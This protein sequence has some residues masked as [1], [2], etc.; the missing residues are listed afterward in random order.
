MGV[1]TPI[2]STLDSFW[3]SAKAG[4]SGVCQITRFDVSAYDVKIAAEVKDFNPDA[5]I[6][7]KEQRRMDMY[8]QYAVA[9]AKMAMQDSGLDMA[10]ENPDRAGVIAGSGIGGLQTLEIQHT[11]LREKGPGRC[12]PFM[13]PQMIS[14]IAA[15]MIAI[16]F[17]MKG[18]NYSVISACATAAHCAGDALRLIQRGDADIMIAGGAEATICGLGI[19]G[20]ASMKALST[21]NDDPAHASR[22]FDRERDGFVMGEGA[23]ML[24]IEELE[25]A[26]KRNARIYC[27]LAGFGMTCDA[28]HI[29]APIEDGSGAGRAMSL[30]MSEA[31]VTPDQVTYI[32]A[33]GTSTPL[34]DKVETLAIKRALGDE[35]ARRVMVSS[36]KSMTGHMLGAAGGIE[37]VVCAMAIRDGIVPPTANYEFPDPD[38]DLDYVPNTARQA[39][40]KVCLNNSLGFGGHSACLLFRKLA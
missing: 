2:G 21:R 33:H 17:N 18:P 35:N 34:N 12:S 38:C 3:A 4:K 14:N 25:H 32:N 31:G 26:K 30:A 19:A 7:K 24:V 27:E 15:G 8:C 13:I 6:A 10:A 5:F 36:T 11:I 16:D 28:N 22:P 40:V 20:F 1:I 37:S 39:D 29:T 9:A 23:A